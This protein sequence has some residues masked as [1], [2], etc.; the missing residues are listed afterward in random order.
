MATSVWGGEDV[1]GAVPPLRVHWRGQCE[2]PRLSPHNEESCGIFAYQTTRAYGDIMILYS[3]S[4][5]WD[6]RAYY[7]RVF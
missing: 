1:C 7:A 3:I 6:T 2:G 4:I 5:I